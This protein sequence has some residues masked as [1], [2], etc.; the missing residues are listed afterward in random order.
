MMNKND[1]PLKKMGVFRNFKIEIKG[2]KFDKSL[3]NTP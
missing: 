2:E 3:P 1:F